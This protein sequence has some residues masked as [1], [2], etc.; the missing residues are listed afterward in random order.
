MS[1]EGMPFFYVVDPS[2]LSLSLFSNFTQ[3]VSFLN[4]KDYH[5]PLKNTVRCI[6]IQG[7]QSSTT[8]PQFTS[9][10]RYWGGLQRFCV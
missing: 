8:L 5:N 7:N 10:S 4:H 2:L 1:V 3:K 6:V 9:L